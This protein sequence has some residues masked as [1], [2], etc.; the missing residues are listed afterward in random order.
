MAQRLPAAADAGGRCICLATSSQV[1]WLEPVALEQQVGHGWA[2]GAALWHVSL[3]A[4]LWIT[5]LWVM[6]VTCAQVLVPNWPCSGACACGVCSGTCRTV[7]SLHTSSGHDVPPHPR[8]ACRSVSCSNAR[9]L[10]KPLTLSAAAPQTHTASQA[11]Q[12]P[13]HNVL[14]TGKQWTEAGDSYS[15]VTCALPPCRYQPAFWQGSACLLFVPSCHNSASDPSQLKPSVAQCE[16]V[17]RAGQLRPLHQRPTP[18]RQQR[19]QQQWRL[20]RQQRSAV[21]APRGSRLHLRRLG[22]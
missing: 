11:H 7:R 2:P 16:L 8:V 10:N 3:C 18:Q 1:L 21:A 13:H 9:G 22:C 14:C 19:R 5:A 6:M 4:V 15:T 12:A 20:Q 17:C